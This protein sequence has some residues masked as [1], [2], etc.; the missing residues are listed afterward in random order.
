MFRFKLFTGEPAH[1]VL[2]N[3]SVQADAGPLLD[4]K[5]GTSTSGFGT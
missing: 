2:V 4:V 5:W 3:L 1:E